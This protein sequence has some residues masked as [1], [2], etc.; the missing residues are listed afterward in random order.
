MSAKRPVTTTHPR[1]TGI[2]AATLFVAAVAFWRP[3]LDVFGYP[4][5]AVLIL[6][7]CIALTMAL[8]EVMVSGRLLVPSGWPAWTAAAFLI[9]V[10]VVWAVPDP[11]VL[12]LM[13]TYA[14]HTGALFYV[15]SATA[16]VLVMRDAVTSDVM[17]WRATRS[18]AL[19]V[20]VTGAAVAGYG[21]LQLVGADPL[22]WIGGDGNVTST[23]G[24]PNFTAALVGAA[25]PAALWGAWD[26]EHHAGLRV[27]AGL[28]LAAL[29]VMVVATGSVQGP[30]TAGIGVVTFLLAAVLGLRDAR[31]RRL[32]LSLWVGVTAVSGVISV[33]GLAGLG[34]FRSLATVANVELRSFYWGAALRMVGRNPLS[35]VGLDRYG[36]Y[37][38]VARSKAAG[39][40]LDLHTAVDAAH[41]VPLQLFATAGILVGIAYLAFAVLTATA[42]IYA[43]RNTSDRARLLVGAIGGVWAGSFAQ[44][45]VS[46]DTPPLSL[47]YW[48]SAGA[49][50]A[51]SDMASLRAVNLPW[52][53]SRG[54][55]DKAFRRRLSATISA[56]VL[57]GLTSVVVGPLQADS[58]AAR[59]I[60]LANA[61][62]SDEALSELE[63]A[64]SR[65]PWEIMHW[66]RL[67]DVA[68]RTG[69]LHLAEVAYGELLARNPRSLEATLTMAR[70]AAHQ[71]EHDKARDLYERALRLEP[72][73]PTLLKEA[74]DY[75]ARQGNRARAEELLSRI[76]ELEDPN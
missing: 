67:A 16:G 58:A 52:V 41:N 54:K 22:E 5:F 26:R 28:V 30:V 44:S 72:T 10:A 38:G 40:R 69:R 34:P 35:G 29:A 42:L 1:A 51:W 19:G 3:G 21:I 49:I 47:M 6:G 57:I 61:E 71:E 13:G 46:I 76:R 23:F 14:R 43:L 53:S 17:R 15:L 74:A 24:N 66:K 11:S 32:S 4:K 2:L 20:L 56:L 12:E 27:A 65:A 70:I 62:R 75:S 31:L 18:V 55:R 36:D 8:H 68:A 63:S 60:A 59:G 45:L 37:F 50:I 48:L 25:V 7:V 33:A 9:A 39:Q 64:T 73:A